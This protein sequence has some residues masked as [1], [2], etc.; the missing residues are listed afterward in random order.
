[1]SKTIEG[2][3][4][5]PKSI[6]RQMATAHGI[7]PSLKADPE[8]VFSVFTRKLVEWHSVELEKKQRQLRKLKG[9]L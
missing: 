6:L 9:E 4:G 2:N 3:S 7:D 5:R 8:V 1:V